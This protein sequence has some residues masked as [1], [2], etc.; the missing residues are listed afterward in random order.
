MKR[1]AECQDEMRTVAQAAAVR[2]SP[3]EGELASRISELTVSHSMLAY[4]Y[5]T[6]IL[7]IFVAQLAKSR[8]FAQRNNTT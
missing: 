5:Y 2:V 6:F 3:V 1:S 4:F 7:L 8:H